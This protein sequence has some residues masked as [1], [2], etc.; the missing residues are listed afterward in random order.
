MAT[1]IWILSLESVPTRYTG[2]WYTHIPALLQDNGFDVVSVDGDMGM[3]E[4]TPGAFLNFAET[5]IWK[6]Q[7][8]IKII[9]LINSGEV[10]DDD[11]I[12]VTDGWNPV[13]LMLRYIK[14]LLGKKFKI[15]SLW[16]AG[17]YIAEDPLGQKMDKRWSYPTEAAMF[18]A[19]DLNVFASKSHISQFNDVMWATAT[20]DKFFRSGFP[21]EYIENIEFKSIPKDNCIVFPHRVSPEKHVEVFDALADMLPQYEFIVPQRHNMGKHEY[22]ST[23]AR[24]KVMF[25]AADLETLGICQYEALWANCLPLVPNHL[26]Y[27]EMYTDD[28][29]RYKRNTMNNIKYLATRIVDMV[30]NY[31][32]YQVKIQ[33]AK[34]FQRENYFSATL[35]INRLKEL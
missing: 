21:M 5:N 11:V 7:Q 26:S 30:E 19:V 22:H 16:H 1:K 29:F 34:E 4:S 14:D 32:A 6:S 28:T 27:A 3:V 8:A 9:Q 23:L 10:K 35:L 17:S 13:V 31:D 20:K 18:N 12:L 24:S 2:Q 33:Q 15:V 25:S